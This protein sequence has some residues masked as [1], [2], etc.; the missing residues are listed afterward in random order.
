MPLAAG[1]LTASSRPG[2][3]SRSAP[4]PPCPAAP[5]APLTWSQ[6]LTTPPVNRKPWPSASN[7]TH[8]R[9]ERGRVQRCSRCSREA[10]PSSSENPPSAHSTVV[11]KPLSEASSCGEGRGGQ[12][13]AV[14]FAEL[15][16]E[17]EE[18]TAP[19]ASL[20]KCLKLKHKKEAGHLC[21]PF[22]LG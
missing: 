17:E 7:A 8:T 12:D 6:A 1:V 4:P 21:L 19:Q 2:S 9:P 16:Q 18:W 14:E 5:A 13:W 22:I 3:P 20:I 11:R 15:V 10:R